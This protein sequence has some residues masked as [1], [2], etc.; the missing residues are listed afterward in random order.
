MIEVDNREEKFNINDILKKVFLSLQ[1]E[2]DCKHC[3]IVYAMDKT[4]PRM[5][6][7]NVKTI[8]EYLIK[9]FHFVSRVSKQ[10]EIL[11]EIYGLK[12]FVYVDDIIFTIKNIK[13]TEED[14]HTLQKNVEHE[15]NV[16]D[17]KLNAYSSTTLTV[18]VPFTISEIGVRRYY[19]LPSKSLLQKNVLII[20]ESKNITL[21]ITKMFKYFPCNVDMGIQKYQEGEYDLSQ[22]HLIVV[23]DQLMTENLNLACKTIQKSNNMKVVIL[24]NMQ[25]LPLSNKS[26]ITSSLAKPVTQE[27]I[28]ELII[29]IFSDEYN[30]S[31]Y[32]KNRKKQNRWQA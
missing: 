18:R 1:K 19:R 5:F 9:V 17:A 6:R 10:N 2:S 7:G 12:E 4:V 27:S 20:A 16:L 3:E 13:L 30:S 28:F 22:Y 32:L 11:V 8:E 26:S 31:D 23:E 24:G 15:S 14:I 29:S 21:S 25:C